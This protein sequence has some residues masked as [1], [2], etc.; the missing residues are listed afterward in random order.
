MMPIVAEHKPEFDRAIEH[1]K[2]DLLSVRSNRATPSLV[3]DLKIEAYGSEMRLKELA[4]LAVP[5]PRTIVVQPWDKTI[6]KDIE[7]SLAKAD[8]NLGMAND[9][10]II[11]LNLPPL[12]EETR[13]ALIK[14]LNQKLE[15]GRVQIR[16]IREKVR[17]QILK[18]EKEKKITE[19]DR[20]QAQKDLDE[21]AKDYTDEINGL[22]KRK[23]EEIT[24]I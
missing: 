15:T 2:T 24:T 7:K 3:E 12:T 9:G 1:L 18:S 20:F 4:S 11:R 13:Q 10:S 17:E 22:G 23:E 6:I 5:E 19:D 16:Q 21:L 14:V 8:L